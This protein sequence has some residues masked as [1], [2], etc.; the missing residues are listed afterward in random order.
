MLFLDQ[1]DFQA[2]MDLVTDHDTAAGF[3][4]ANTAATGFISI[5]TKVWCAKPR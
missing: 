2:D 3:A 4:E 1:L 5:T